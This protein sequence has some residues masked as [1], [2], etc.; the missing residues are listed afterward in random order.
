M[1][2]TFSPTPT[3]LPYS[4]P[5]MNPCPTE[6]P[7]NPNMVTMPRDYLYGVAMV[8]IIIFFINIMYT[9]NLYIKYKR[10]NVIVANPIV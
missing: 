1:S 8:V 10:T 7:P 3:Q 2:S 9:N 4:P 5:L 6:S